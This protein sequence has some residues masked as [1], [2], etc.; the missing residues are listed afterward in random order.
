MKIGRKTLEELG[1][2][3][4]SER[5]EHGDAFPGITSSLSEPPTDAARRLAPL[6]DGDDDDDGVVL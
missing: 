2:D 1:E 5:H 4:G 3:R 6:R